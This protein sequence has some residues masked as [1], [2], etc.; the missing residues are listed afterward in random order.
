MMASS[1]DKAITLKDS[2]VDKL[3]KGGV[4]KPVQGMP[5][6]DHGEVALEPVSTMVGIGLAAGTVMHHFPEINKD[7]GGYWASPK[8]SCENAKKNRVRSNLK[9]LFGI[10]D[11]DSHDFNHRHFDKTGEIKPYTTEQKNCLRKHSGGY[12]DNYCDFR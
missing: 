4:T 11:Y 12:P 10:G 9:N 6:T 3:V 1:K 7:L 2:Y 5:E 8:G